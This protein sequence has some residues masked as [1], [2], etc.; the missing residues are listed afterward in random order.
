MATLTQGE[1]A[2]RDG[3]KMA[4]GGSFPPP[5]TGD[6]ERQLRCSFDFK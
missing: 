3:S 6:G 2:V 4:H 5:S 1:N